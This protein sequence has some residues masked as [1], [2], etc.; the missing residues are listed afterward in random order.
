MKA[1]PR[2]IHTEGGDKI[3]IFATIALFLALVV[4]SRITADD[5]SQ[6]PPTTAK[7]EK[8]EPKKSTPY[9][10]TLPRNK[11]VPVKEDLTLTYVSQTE[12]GMILLRDSQGHDLYFRQGK[13]AF[14]D[15]QMEFP[16]I[17]EDEV[18][19][20]VSPQIKTDKPLAAPKQ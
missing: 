6:P 13:T 9:Q 17:A 18:V 16:Q 14:A 15:V 4:I 1:N 3:L 12:D 10:R 5:T 7:Q 11:P 2:K 20:K 19:I 8:E